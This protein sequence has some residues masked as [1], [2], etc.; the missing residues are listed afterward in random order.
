MDAASPRSAWLRRPAAQAAAVAAA[1][2][3][4]YANTFSAS[5]HFDDF[6]AIV[7]NAAL[8]DMDRF[9]ASHLGS[10]MVGYLS[11]ALDHRLH[12]LDVRGYHAV[13]LL[14]HISTAL[15]VFALARLLFRTPALAGSRLQAD[16][17]LVALLAALL[18]AVHPVQTQAVTYVVQRLASL[19]TFFSVLAVVAWLRWR[20][21][22]GAAYAV[23]LAATFLALFTKE[24]AATLPLLLVLCELVFF[25]GSPRRLA[26]LVPFLLAIP[27]LVAAVLR[28]GPLEN[29]ISVAGPWTGRIITH[30]E[31]LATELRVV[32][33]YLR[34]LVWPSGQTLFYDYPVH[35][36]F[37]DPPVLASLLLLAALAALA[38]WIFARWRQS[39]PQARLVAFGIA[40][41]FV[42]LSVESGAVVIVD[43]IYEHRLYYPS[44]GAF[45]AMA[46]GSVWAADGLARRWP[47]ARRAL[48]FCAAAALAGLAVATFQRNRVWA[49]D[50]S[51]WEDVARKAP[52]MPAAQYALGLALA[53]AGL[54]ERAEAAHLRALALNPYFVESYPALAQLRLRGGRSDRAWHALAVAAYL[55]FDTG[56]ALELWNRALAV[57]PGLAEAHYGRA[58]ALAG[59]GDGEG[60]RDEMELGCRLGSEGACRARAG[61][62]RELPAP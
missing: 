54:A 25:E 21:A 24:S 18:F 38:V 19:S 55:S 49:D 61:G 37:A 33:T 47:G 17:D 35:R 23:A 56:R 15:L 32:V 45:L 39:A 46:A 26:P 3:A 7:E 10:R 16:A 52:R 9:W 42:A 31:Y 41:F 53:D 20:I 13:N 28:A 1:A 14:V 6:H 57:S 36:S 12:G 2:V 59:R 4:C 5:F 51:L 43:V 34:L 48:A 29:Q 40:W 58:L 11:F 60:S 44:V 27:L 22:G 8:R 50:V 62:P 30:G